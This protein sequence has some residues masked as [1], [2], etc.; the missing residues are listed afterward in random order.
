VAA[1]NDA[2][3][4]KLQ[5]ELDEQLNRLSQ[6]DLVRDLRERAAA[7]KAGNATAEASRKALDRAAAIAT[8]LAAPP[9]ARELMKPASPSA[10][11]I[12]Q[13]S[14]QAWITAEA[15]RMKAAGEIPD[16]IRITDFANMLHKRM[17]HAARTDKSLRVVRWQHIKNSLRGW[18]L[19]PISKI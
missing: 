19:W 18:G 17:S 7:E 15:K 3:V 4:R 9:S 14:T 8:G 16:D 5:A 2:Q 12:R 13:G 10:V 1:A 6:S 11:P